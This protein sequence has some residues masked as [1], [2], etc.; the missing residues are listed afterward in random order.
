MKIIV[1]AGGVGTR[2]WPVSRKNTP[3]QFEKIIG[4][5][6]TLEQTIE[7]LLSLY[8][9]QDIYIAT[10]KRYE[11][12]IKKQLSQIPY[13]NFILEPEMRDVGPAIGLA[14]S[15]LAKKYGDEPLAILWSDHIVKN[16]DV[17]KKILFLAEE[18]IKRKQ[19][20]F[21][22]LAQKPRFANQNMGW[23][24]VGDLKQ[25]KNG[26]SVYLFKKLIYR[27]DLSDATLFYNNENFVWNLGYFVTTPNY[28]CSLFKTFTPDMYVKLEEISQSY[29]S[30]MFE[31]KLKLLYPTLEKISFD[32][33][34]LV[35]M[36]PSNVLVISGDLGWSDVGAWESLKEALT[37]SANDNVTNG[38]VLLEESH[39][40]LVFNYN[41]Q[42]VVGI[43][44]NQMLVIN[45]RDVLLVCPKTAVPKIKKLVESLSGTAHEHLA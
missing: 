37:E 14:A 15:I 18:T 1:F 20:H 33:A 45:T 42:L 36:K 13:S 9:P 22:F 5:K 43:D 34:I 39:D 8:K 2:L 41:D 38:K 17:F 24:E 29:G 35:K 28:L 30:T 31:K 23:I 27:P 19:T 3:K 12:I 16:A 7:R 44:L 40:S 32:D 11:R 21:I 25:K 10:G 6:S 26:V 4:D